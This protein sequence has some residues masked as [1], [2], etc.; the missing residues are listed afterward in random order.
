MAD[1]RAGFVDFSPGETER[2]W[3]ELWREEQKRQKAATLARGTND[4]GLVQGYK[5]LHVAS[6]D[7]P[8]RPIISGEERQ[9]SPPRGMMAEY[10]ESARQTVEQILRDRAAAEA[11][12]AKPRQVEAINAF[13]PDDLRE[14]LR[15][16]LLHPRAAAAEEGKGYSH[17]LT[18]DEFLPGQTAALLPPD[19]AVE[20]ARSSLFLAEL[21]AEEEEKRAQQ[22]GPGAVEVTEL[23]MRAEELINS[24]RAEVAAV[25]GETQR[26]RRELSQLQRVCDGVAL[27]AAEAPFPPG[28]SPPQRRVRAASSPRRPGHYPPVSHA[29]S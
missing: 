5:D 3:I 12:K 21:D 9:M 4:A 8:I 13:N 2:R 25:R 16:M 28:F 11:S 18:V 24:R 22:P 26:L 14:Y 6:M 17:R 10:R 7:R 27:Q 29:F 20:A 1:V 23:V 15:H 19:Y